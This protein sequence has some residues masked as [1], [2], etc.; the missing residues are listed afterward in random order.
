MHTDRILAYS[1]AAAN[2]RLWAAAP[3]L[4]RALEAIKARIAGEF[5]NPS[6]EAFGPLSA[7]TIADINSFASAALAKARE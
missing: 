5:D 1:R 2:A 7:D 6:L 4:V 3:D